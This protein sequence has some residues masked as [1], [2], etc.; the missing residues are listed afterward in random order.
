MLKN[1]IRLLIGLVSAVL[2]L[3]A[4]LVVATWAPDRPLAELRGRWA[5]SPSEFLEVAGMMVHVRDEGP[6]D[7]PHPIVLIHGTAASLH[8]WEGWV[9]ALKSQRRVIRFDLPGFGLTGPSPEGDYSIGRYVQFTWALLDKL[10]VRRCVLVGNSLG[11]NV[12]WETAL[13]QPQRV[14]KLILVDALG[15]P[16]QSTSVPIGFRIARIPVLNRLMQFT[17]A[18][19][20]IESSVRNVYGDPARVTPELVDR[21]FELTLREGNRAALVQ[22]FRQGM[23]TDGSAKR[24]AELKLPVLV[25]WG[26][27]DR[28]IP[29]ENAE[30][31][32]HDIVGSE[33]IIFDD[34]GHVPHEEDPTRT[35]NAAMKFLGPR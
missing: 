7:D 6:R 32:R 26:G 17:L 31:F 1:V 2:L 28:L 12:A 11:G 3:V 35:V 14:E 30:R 8:T 33:L 27:R 15:Y 19:S 13:A 16:M 5:P 20:F 25:L 4:V 29:P 18:R 34:L 21:Y 23:P 24:I 9:G 10:G 22:R